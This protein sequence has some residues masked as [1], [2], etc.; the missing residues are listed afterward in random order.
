[1]GIKK[2]YKFLS[3]L[4]LV[5]EYANLGKYVGVRR[6]QSNNK[7][8]V[9]GIDYWLYAHKF[10][11]SYGNM[12][13]GFWN[14]IIKLLSH[15]II[16]LYIY[17]GKP[18][19]EKDPIIQQRKRKRTNLETKLNNVCNEMLECNDSQLE[20]LEDQKMKIK[21]SIIYIKKNDIDIIKEFFDVLHIPYL[22]AIGEADALCAKLYK[23]GIISACLSDDMD[24]LAL[25]CGITI[26]FQ[27]GKVLEFDLDHILDKLKITYNQFVEMCIMFGCDYIKLPFK[28][29]IN[30]SYKL[31]K[32]HGN[33][34]NILNDANHVNLNRQNE[35]CK[36]F[37]NG[38]KNAKNLLTLS[39]SKENIDNYNPT[40]NKEIDAFM[41]LSYLKKYGDIKYVT[42][43]MDNI[44]NSIN[45]INFHIA[46]NSD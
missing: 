44:V 1:M 23:D 38:Y 37:I 13:I 25:G 43:N 29:D 18:P 35:K 8:I 27:E 31:I 10:S 2:L 5:K 34:E 6:K 22:T 33:I 19:Y 28:L 20:I 45:Y 16:P 9:F 42:D 39:S 14:Q 12:I 46:R 17:D 40:I 30:E 15:N 32:T 24:M 4:D 26:K 3:E 7:K 36:M 11:Y 21:K 41:V